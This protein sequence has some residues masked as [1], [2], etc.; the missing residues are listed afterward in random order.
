MVPTFPETHFNAFQ[1]IRLELLHPAKGLCASG[2]ATSASWNAKGGVL[3]VL[4]DC[5]CILAA[6]NPG[7]LWPPLVEELDCYQLLSDDFNCWFQSFW[8]V[9]NQRLTPK[10]QTKCS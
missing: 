10:P 2:K 4:L 9:L 8:K 1:W 7:L 3:P 5:Y 6:R